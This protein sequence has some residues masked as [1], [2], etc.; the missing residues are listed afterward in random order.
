MSETIS[1][2]EARTQAAEWLERH[3]AGGWRDEDQA[4]LDAWLAA[5]PTNRVAYLRV[6]SAWTKADRLAALNLPLPRRSAQVSRRLFPVLLR[7][8]AGF[9]LLA[10]IS[11]AAFNFVTR[12]QAQTF[13][14]AIGGHKL[15]HLRDG[16]SVEMNTNT[17]VEVIASANSRTVRILRGE[18]YFQIHHNAAHPFVVYAQGRRITDLGTEF[19][20]RTHMSGLKVALISGSA[21]LDASESGNRKFV[22]L[23]PGEVAIAKKDSISLAKEPLDQIVDELAWRRGMLV[24]RHITLASAA[25][26]FN[27]YNARKLVITNDIADLKINGTFAK[28][29]I[30]AFSRSAQYAL[31][32]HVALLDHEIV[33]SR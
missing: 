6:K 14:T 12:S 9:G 22:L 20:V 32:L 33:L 17:A 25:A 26:E 2:R 4:A 11:L 27:R 10:I 5:A 3:L 19:L 15:I 21:R 29:S 28:G 7:L 31:G 8:S 24:F 23:K 30:E 13:A 16:S 1:A 18:V